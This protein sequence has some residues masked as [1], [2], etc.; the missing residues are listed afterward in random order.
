VAAAKTKPDASAAKTKPAK[1]KPFLVGPVQTQ[2]KDDISTRLA[3]LLWGAATCGK[4]TLAA[5]AP[6]HKL[7][8]SLGDNEHT[9]VIHRDDV[10]VAN[11]S[12]LSYEDLF[13]HGQND[14]PFGLD[15]ILREHEE[16]ATVVVDSATALTF[17]A[18]QKSVSKGVGASRTFTPTMEQPGISAYGGRN[19]IVLECLTGILKVT[20]RYNV[21]VIVTAH[22]ADPVMKT[23]NNKE[24]IDYISLQLGGQLVNNMTWR[25]SEIWYMSQESGAQGRRRLAVRATRFRRPMKTRMFS[26]KGPAEFFVEYDADKPDDK[27]MTIASM[28][29][30]WVDNGYQKID[31]PNNMLSKGK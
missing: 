22:E 27:Q 25:L 21:H 8:L 19:A 9:P 26:G 3:L 6:G 30:K 11:L 7:W 1:S 24:V 5:T 4:S 12:G 2:T 31:V 18:L 23:E 20:S 17:R 14:N 15:Q 16:I 29:N 28:H 13:K 10:T